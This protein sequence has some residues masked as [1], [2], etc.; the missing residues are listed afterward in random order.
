M[1]YQ[2]YRLI[3]FLGIFVLLTTLASSCMLVLKGGMRAAHPYRRAEGTAHGVAA[4]LILLGGFGMLAR[5]GIV[6][7]GLPIWVWLKLTIW[8]LLTAALA[9]VY[10]GV[11][12]ARVVLIT[13]PLVAVLAAAIASY[14]PF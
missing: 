3:H 14:K 5:L 7:D 6:Q 1:P 9:L 8:V 10:R 12:F 4:F 11:R 2:V 13:A